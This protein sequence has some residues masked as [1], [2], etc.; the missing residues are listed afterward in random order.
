MNKKI[1]A[2]FLTAA[3]CLGATSCGLISKKNENETPNDIDNT[4]GVDANGDTENKDANG[5]AKDDADIVPDDTEN[6]NTD[7]DVPEVV[8][9]VINPDLADTKTAKAEEI[10]DG[11]YFMALNIGLGK[12]ENGNE[13]SMYCEYAIDENNSYFRF[14]TE[15]PSMDFTLLLTPETQYTI[16]NSSKQ[17]VE[18]V[19]E[20]LETLTSVV[21]RIKLGDVYKK[22]A[23]LASEK[24]TLNGVEY[25]SETF[26]DEN[27]SSDS[28]SKYL[29]DSDGNLKYIIFTDAETETVIEV[30]TLTSELPEGIFE[31]PEGYTEYVSTNTDTEA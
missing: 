27:G 6:G 12:D 2:L 20:A 28:V 22:D 17:Y 14:T 5:E 13:S 21:K 11:D 24:M 16:D 26:E 8:P 29:F 25:D 1:C 19:A 4:V 15:K 23:S 9:E 3:L 31:I 18:G 7:A 10:L 30:K